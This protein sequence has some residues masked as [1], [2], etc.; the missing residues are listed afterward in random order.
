MDLKKIHQLLRERKSAKHSDQPIS[1]S[2][3]DAST[4]PEE[5]SAEPAIRDDA[6]SED[7]NEILEEIKSRNSTLYESM[8]KLN[9]NQMEAI[10][11]N[12]K[13]TLVSAMVGSGKTTVLV[14]K[15][16][17]LH[18]I[19]DVPLNDMAVLTFTNKAANEIKERITIFYM[20]DNAMD[21]PDLS[22]FGTFHAVARSVL[23]SSHNLPDLGYTPG[24]TIM[25]ENERKEFYLRIADELGLNI[26]YKNKV[27]KRIE[28]YFQESTRLWESGTLYGN[29]KYED[30]IKE[31]IRLGQERKKR[32]NVMDFDDLIENVNLL[33]SHPE[34]DF[35]PKWIIVDEFQ[36]CSPEQIKM[37][38]NMASDETSIFAV[39]DPNQ[40]IYAWRGS[41]LSIFYDFKA[42]DCKEYHLPI[43]YRSTT[44]I[45][46]VAKYFISYDVKELNGTREAGVPVSLV[47]H[48]D[49]NQEAIYLAT[50]IKSLNK[51]GIPF[52][53]IAI[54]VRTRQQMEIFETVF[55]KEGIPFEVANRRTLHDIPP[56]YWLT[57]LLK[58]CLN[59]QDIN[60]VYD[61]ICHETYGIVESSKVR[62]QEYQI[63][64]DEFKKITELE[65]FT[66][67]IFLNICK[68]EKFLNFSVKMLNFESWLENKGSADIPNIFDYFDLAT[69]L[70]PASIHYPK[71]VELVKSYLEEISKYVQMSQDAD[72]KASL[73]AAL[74]DVSVGGHQIIAETIDPNSEKIKLLTMHSAKGL[75]FRYVF[76]SGAN[77]GLIPLRRS[78]M[79]S[80]ELE[81]EKRLF[82]VAITRAKDYL[83]ISYH[84]NPEGWNSYPEPSMFIGCIPQN[85]LNSKY[86]RTLPVEE[87]KCD[88]DNIDKV[89]QWCLGQRIRHPKYGPGTICKISK[90]N[91]VCNFE[92]FGEKSFSISFLPIV[93]FADNE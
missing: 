60:C 57:K 8:K 84:T 9:Q 48:Y 12:N 20:Q 82:F 2:G 44:K 30:D 92:K 38:M 36:D 16:L 58:A 24:F 26:K 68:D 75:E 25:D 77:N 93:P 21:S 61:A 37:I 59:K 22:L 81:E 51:E 63:R 80:K 50:N 64:S 35:H 46:D 17:Y 23:L 55:E 54:L 69:Y 47:N 52:R 43:N 53:E 88:N 6:I 3:G 11:T 85:L 34:N 87:A 67:W 14:H 76:I 70:R 7:Y 45:L 19:K 1:S 83:E 89:D 42:N 72:M 56:L 73:L 71:E 78:A 10:F 90:A 32:N 31:L 33:L 62:L 5:Q 65:K 79:N 18:F 29:M 4:L 41:D 13:K 49:S 15:V 39:G 27:E 91:I 74:S 86:T 28:R 66:D 40:L